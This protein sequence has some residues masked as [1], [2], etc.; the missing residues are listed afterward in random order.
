M[1]SLFSKRFSFFSER[2]LFQFR[3]Y[4]V[5]SDEENLYFIASFSWFEKNKIILP[6]E[7]T[8]TKITV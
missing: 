7:K 3:I 4:K 5:G 1:K 6:I 8:L 2:I